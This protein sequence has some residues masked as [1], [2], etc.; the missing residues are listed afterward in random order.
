MDKN[1]PL[2]ANI[3]SELYKIMVNKIAFVG[4]RGAGRLG[5]SPPHDLDCCCIIITM[6]YSALK[7]KQGTYLKYFLNESDEV[8]MRSLLLC[9]A[10]FF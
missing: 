5:R 6:P 8:D 9:K 10:N 7:F 1:A 2:I 4:F 3:F